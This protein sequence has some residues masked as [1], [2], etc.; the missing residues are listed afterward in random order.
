[1]L[2]IYTYIVTTI[3][4]YDWSIL[5]TLLRSCNYQEYR[6]TVRYLTAIIIEQVFCCYDSQ[7]KEEHYNGQRP[8]PR[9]AL[10][11]SVA[12]GM[13]L[14]SIVISYSYRIHH[15][16]CVI[17]SGRL[18]G[19]R[20]LSGIDVVERFALEE[21]LFRACCRTLNTRLLTRMSTILLCVLIITCRLAY[22]ITSFSI[23]PISQKP[24]YSLA[25]HHFDTTYRHMKDS[26]FFLYEPSKHSGNM[27][28]GSYCS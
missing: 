23:P 8:S 27:I 25:D 13:L 20:A 28:A 7:F 18:L 14:L 9:L 15:F 5:P 6:F 21:R 19:S 1:M 10:E 11:L 22:G 4:R 2:L 12:I 16:K 3:T 24:P 26:S 17:S